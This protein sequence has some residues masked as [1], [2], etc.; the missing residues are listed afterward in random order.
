MK[1]YLYL[2]IVAFSAGLVF[3]FWRKASKVFS[4]KVSKALKTVLLCSILF[5]GTGCSVV[6]KRVGNSVSGALNT[7][8]LN[9][10]DLQLIKD[11]AP[12][13]MLLMD[14]VL[15]SEPANPKIYNS[16]ASL[17]SAYAGVFVEDQER[18]LLLSDR[19]FGYSKTALCLDVKALCNP[20]TMSFDDF[21]HG[22]KTAKK[23]DLSTLYTTASVW[24]GWVQTRK[25]DWGAIAHLA[26]VK[27]MMAQVVAFDPAYQL[28]QAQM[29]MG[30][31]ESLVPPAAG[32]DLDKARKH[33]EK[34]D[35]LAEGKN[36]FVKVLLAENYAR[37]LFDQELHD[38]LLQEVLAAEVE[39]EGLTLMNVV[40]QDEARELLRTSDEYFN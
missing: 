15:A 34:A 12:A 2:R 29:Y 35:E 1:V 40:A 31:L 21:E 10:N 7:A 23:S 17:Y 6:V 8:V 36:L 25:D 18:A 14:S 24:A 38:R 11:G 13:Y 19:A 37:M 4:M 16:A 9:H 3:Q 20:E 27:A 5:V 33:F 28:G 30:V 26:K 22:L 39:A 32:G